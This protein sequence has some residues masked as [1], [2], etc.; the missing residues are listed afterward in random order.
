MILV[1]PPSVDL[2]SS[3]IHCTV[4]ATPAL[5]TLHMADAQSRVLGQSASCFLE[6]LGAHTMGSRLAGRPPR[7]RAPTPLKSISHLECY[8][9]LLDA[10]R[11]QLPPARSIPSPPFSALSSRSRLPFLHAG[12]P[13][14]GL[15]SAATAPSSSPTRK[16]CA[17]G[18]GPCACPQAQV[19]LHDRNYAA[20]HPGTLRMHDIP[21]V[22]PTRPAQ[23]DGSSFTHIAF[24][25][26]V[27]LCENVVS[28]RSLQQLSSSSILIRY[29]QRQ[30][31]YASTFSSFTLIDTPLLFF[32]YTLIRRSPRFHRR[33]HWTAPTTSIA[34]SPI[35]GWHPNVKSSS[36]TR[37]KA[38]QAMQPYFSR[39]SYRT[40]AHRLRRRSI[41][42]A[43]RPP[44]CE[45]G[46]ERDG[47]VTTAMAR[48]TTVSASAMTSVCMVPASSHG[49]YYP[50]DSPLS[51][52]ICIMPFVCALSGFYSAR[53]CSAALLLL[54]AHV[55]PNP[56]PRASQPPDK[57]LHWTM[58]STAFMYPLRTPFRPSASIS[59][60]GGD[61]FVCQG[62][63]NRPLSPLPRPSPYSTSRRCIA[64]IARPP[65][66][67]T[68]PLQRAHLPSG[69]P[70]SV[71][72]V[73]SSLSQRASRGCTPRVRWSLAEIGGHRRA[74]ALHACHMD[75]DP[76]TEVVP[77]GVASWRG[78]DETLGVCY[79]AG[80]VVGAVVRIG[81]EL[82]EGNQVQSMPVLSSKTL[83]LVVSI[84]RAVPVCRT[85]RPPA[86]A[87]IL[88]RAW[89]LEF[90]DAAGERWDRAHPRLTL[91][92][93]TEAVPSAFPASTRIS[94][95]WIHLPPRRF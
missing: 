75:A 45:D 27:Q 40:H 80:A 47:I 26:G 68:P 14:R 62:S 25:A 55:Y 93:D 16:R 59:I 70:P 89:A 46:M 52:P 28:F 77:G 65:R 67:R 35:A 23:V 74:R 81:L 71:D 37:L 90:S 87:L 15:L 92:L 72:D 32:S 95:S 54:L 57:R 10:P 18:G 42:C 39:P 50:N 17:G 7:R 5:S 64:V 34:S 73:V 88:A 30:S 33:R 1:R 12:L 41:F 63:E 61:T 11:P 60:N 19:Q 24:S 44:G 83:A 91:P 4:S 94:S 8:A 86:R 36:F 58:H 66:T 31:A 3:P 48:P 79:M 85:L 38:P 13:A 82:D 69:A 49:M 20:L 21:L 6:Q 53:V 78:E 43:R 29:R 84:P 56:I 9:A 22:D 2:A 76:R 51:W